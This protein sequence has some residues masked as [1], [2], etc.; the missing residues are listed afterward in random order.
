[1]GAEFGSIGVILFLGI[2]VAGAA[3]ALQG[4]KPAA[5]IAVAAWCALAIHSMIDHLYE[6]PLVVL[7]AGIVLGVAGRRVER[8]PDEPG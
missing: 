1:M 5:L 7:T 2:L 8:D 4:R 6:Y 3:V